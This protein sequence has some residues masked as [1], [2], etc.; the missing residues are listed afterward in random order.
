LPGSPWDYKSSDIIVC[1]YGNALT[2]FKPMTGAL[3]SRVQFQTYFSYFD[4]LDNLYY[5]VADAP[6]GQVPDKLYVISP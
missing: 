5:C 3:V 6:G 1:N 2:V 4:N